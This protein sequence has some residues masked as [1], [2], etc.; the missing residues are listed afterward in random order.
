[1]A[2]AAAGSAISRTVWA[3]MPWAS[4]N[5]T[6]SVVRGERPSIAA[7]RRVSDS[8]GDAP[9]KRSRRSRLPGVTASAA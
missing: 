5:V 4:S 2:M 3:A 7:R 8:A 6:T 1:M 9:L